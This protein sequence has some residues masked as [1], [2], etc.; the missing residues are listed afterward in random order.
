MQLVFPAQKI[1]KIRNFALRILPLINIEILAYVLNRLGNGIV[2]SLEK[3]VIFLW[4]V[5]FFKWAYDILIY[6]VFIFIAKL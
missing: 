5:T 6:S 4:I 1:L 2:H 3:S